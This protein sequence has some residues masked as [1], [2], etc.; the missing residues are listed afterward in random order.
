MFTQKK[1]PNIRIY[2]INPYLCSVKNN[3]KLISKTVKQVRCL[4]RGRSVYKI[5]PR[6]L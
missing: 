6:G 1:A 4:I 2:K 3:E 5:S